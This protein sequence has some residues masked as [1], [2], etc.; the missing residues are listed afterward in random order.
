MTLASKSKGEIV[1][2]K[3]LHRAPG[4]PHYYRVRA[5]GLLLLL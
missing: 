2:D 3:V 5:M 4:V 1:P